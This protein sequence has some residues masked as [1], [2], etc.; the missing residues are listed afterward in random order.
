MS[1]LKRNTLDGWLLVRCNH[2]R[3]CPA[4]VQ[5]SGNSQEEIRCFVIKS[6]F[7]P[8]YFFWV[9]HN[10][11]I[12]WTFTKITS[13]GLTC[14][15]RCLQS[16]LPQSVS[17]QVSSLESIKI[18]LKEACLLA[19]LASCIA[20]S[21]ALFATLHRRSE[22]GTDREESTCESASTVRELT[23]ILLTSAHEWPV[24]RLLA[25]PVHRNRLKW[26]SKCPIFQRTHQNQI[27]WSQHTSQYYECYALHQAMPL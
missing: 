16:T 5:L 20:F 17:N 13:W 24:N 18:N 22:T 1:P 3:T 6:P 10:P 2:T 19:V 14:H 7:I 26:Y 12:D 15:V 25:P 11:N 27:A 23:K 21:V 8:L 4:H 9:T